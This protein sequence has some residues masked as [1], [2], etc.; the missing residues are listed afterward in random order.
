MGK[1]CDSFQGVVSKLQHQATYKVLHEH[2][3]W[4]PESTK[5]MESCWQIQPKHAA[6]EQLNRTNNQTNIWTTK[7]G[8]DGADFYLV[9]QM[10]EHTNPEQIRHKL[11][12]ANFSNGISKSMLHESWAFNL[13]YK[14]G[15]L[16]TYLRSTH[17]NHSVQLKLY[18]WSSRKPL[19]MQQ[20]YDEFQVLL[21]K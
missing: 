9:V 17:S 3:P 4:N 20:I 7:P 10:I 1:W 19:S 21:Q 8:I 11:L 14:H 12:H 15:E 18:L 2:I 13:E 5:Q 6:W 16:V